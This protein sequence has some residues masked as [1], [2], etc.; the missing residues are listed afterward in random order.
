MTQKALFQLRGE[1]CRPRISDSLDRLKR[2]HPHRSHAYA[3]QNTMGE[4]DIWSGN[5]QPPRWVTTYTDTGG[6]LKALEIK[7]P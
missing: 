4:F 2:T 7:L 6:D 5:G 1:E 3:M